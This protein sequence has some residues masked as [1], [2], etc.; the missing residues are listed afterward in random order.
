VVF[1]Y[2]RAA[3]G[4][5]RRVIVVEGFSDCLRVYQAGFAS[6]VALMGAALSPQQADLLAGRFAE[7]VPMLDGDPAGQAGQHDAA[8]KLVPRC[9]VHRV[10]LAPG[11][12]PDEMSNEEIRQALTN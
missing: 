9:W 5:D 8:A 12:Q 3:A 2:H 10:I 4:S 7:I 1:N 6:G 11:R